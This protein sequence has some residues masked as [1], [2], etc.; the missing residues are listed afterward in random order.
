MQNYFGNGCFTS[1]VNRFLSPE[2]LVDDYLIFL[3]Q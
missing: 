1:I 2:S 3:E